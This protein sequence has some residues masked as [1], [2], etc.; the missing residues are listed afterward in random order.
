MIAIIASAVPGRLLA[1]GLLPPAP[2][3][4]SRPLR[5]RTIVVIAVVASLALG[6]GT[7]VD[8]RST[9]TFIRRFQPW[10]HVDVARRRR[11]RARSATRGSGAG[12]FLDATI[13]DQR[14]RRHITRFAHDMPLEVA[15]ELGGP[16][17]LFV[18]A[19]YAGSMR[20]LWRARRSSARSG[21]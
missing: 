16:G 3:G 5:L 19:L 1:R 15:A 20:A 21:W 8:Q 13:L 12:T 11:R 17:L 18:L 7:P 4:G 9:R 10:P 6:L 14:D 2:R